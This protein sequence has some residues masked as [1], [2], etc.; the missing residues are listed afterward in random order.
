LNILSIPPNRLIHRHISPL[1]ANIF[2][3]PEARDNLFN[4]AGVTIV[5][6][7]SANKVGSE[8]RGEEEEGREGNLSLE[9]V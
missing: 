3:T 8:R 7:S 1:G 5:K 4:H 6:D 2:T 9:I